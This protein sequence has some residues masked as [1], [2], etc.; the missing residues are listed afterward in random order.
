M[1]NLKFIY[2]LGLIVLIFGCGTAEDEFDPKDFVS[3]IVFSESFLETSGVGAAS[4]D[5]TTSSAEA[6]RNA[7]LIAEVQAYEIMAEALQ[8]V[9]LI[10]DV[11]LR[12]VTIDEGIL[13]QIVETNLENV[14][15]VGETRFHQEEDGSWMAGVTMRMENDDVNRFTS[16]V[17]NL[18][19]VRKGIN[20]AFDGSAGDFEYTGIILD[21]RM[22]YGF[23]SLLAPKV[24]SPKGEELFSIRDFSAPALDARNSIPVYSTY[25]EAA[26][27]PK[28]VGSTPLKLMVIGIAAD[29]SAV[30]L[31]E[32]DAKKFRE[33]KNSM[34]L[35]REGKVALV[36]R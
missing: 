29:T 1:K 34:Q 18:P 17:M 7:E 27:D 28:G 20:P 13:L 31:S 11:G 22:M 4:S 32:K 8:G 14:V 21:L 24:L 2:C 25:H 5:G 33:S 23:R 26:A 15:K 10:G 9:G 12:D 6:K 3:G 36:Y 16:R 19:E 30:Y 35:V